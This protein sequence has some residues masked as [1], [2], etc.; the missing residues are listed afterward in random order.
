MNWI[1]KGFELQHTKDCY[2]FHD[3]CGIK[4]GNE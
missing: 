1:E 3:R 2:S 4:F